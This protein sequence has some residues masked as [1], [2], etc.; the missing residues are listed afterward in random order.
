M[1]DLQ[2]EDEA[3]KKER[4]MK[5]VSRAM[6]RVVPL[7]AALCCLVSKHLTGIDFRIHIL[8]IFQFH[9]LL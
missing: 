3:I 7:I 5:R 1:C 8:M 6:K 4:M 9:N 2:P